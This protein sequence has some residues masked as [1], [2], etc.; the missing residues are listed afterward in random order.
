MTM[1]YLPRRQRLLVV[2]A[3]TA[4]LAFVPG[5]WA[6]TVT[7][8]VG[9][10]AT[11]VPD[12][13]ISAFSNLAFGNYLPITTHAAANLDANGSV[14]VACTNGDGAIIEIGEGANAGVGS[15]PAAPVRR[16]TDGATHYLNYHLYSDS[17]GG[18]VWGA[19]AAVDKDVTGNGTAVAHTIYGRIPSG[20][21]TA[22]VGSY[23]DTVV[24][25]V[26]F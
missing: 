7:Q 25:T 16:M 14:T 9:V 6:G 4:A 15:T 23:T 11:V 19:G 20:Q 5:V 3:I 17:A 21:T 10:S 13:N 8:N 12:C 22:Y 18:T 24:V 2:T 1:S 26:T